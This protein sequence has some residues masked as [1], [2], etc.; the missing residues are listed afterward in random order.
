MPGWNPGQSVPSHAQTC[1]D[2]LVCFWFVAAELPVLGLRGLASL[3]IV[4][5]ERL[6]R[7]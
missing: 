4:H 2:L 1:L 6:I 3:K 5:N 7:F